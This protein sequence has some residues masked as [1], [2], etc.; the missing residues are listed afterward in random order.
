[1]TF[2]DIRAKMLGDITNKQACESELTQ[3]LNS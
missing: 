3:A 2:I 1:V